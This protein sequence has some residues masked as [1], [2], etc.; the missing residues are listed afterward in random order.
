M[1]K[2][3]LQ[4]HQK[5]LN[6]IQKDKYNKEILIAILNNKKVQR[7]SRQFSPKLIRKKDT[8]YDTELYHRL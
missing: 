7:R 2:Q 6:A 3:T 1:E 5:L 8:S 4:E